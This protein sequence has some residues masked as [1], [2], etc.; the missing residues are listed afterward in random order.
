MKGLSTCYDHEE[1]AFPK[2]VPTAVERITAHYLHDL[3][4]ERQSSEEI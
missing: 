1:Y 2:H 4:R 3:N